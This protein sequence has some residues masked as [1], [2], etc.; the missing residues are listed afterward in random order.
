MTRRVTRRTVLKAGLIGNPAVAVAGGGATYWWWA[1][2]A[3]D[4]VG[5]VSFDHPL[6]IPPLADSEIDG[7]GRRV[8]ELVAQEGTSR[9][10]P[11]V[12]SETWGFNGSYLGLLAAQ[13]E[14]RRLS[15]SPGERAEIIVRM[16]PGG[17]VVLRSYQP[18]L[19]IDWFTNGVDGGR[20][21]FDLLELRAANTLAPSSPMPNRL[22]SPPDLAD[23][24]W[25]AAADRIFAL[26]GNKIN[27]NAMDMTRV[28]AVVE[29][30]TTEVWQVE[31]TD[32]NFHNVHVH[33]VQFHITT[34]NG[35]PPAPEF[36]GRKDTVF[37]Q[38]G[39]VAQ[40]A[41]R[42]TDYTDPNLPCMFHCHRLRHEDRGMMGQFVVVEPGQLPTL[43]N[44]AEHDEEGDQN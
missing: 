17:N 12:V 40:L 1:S 38:P 29:V 10:L 35:E 16:R 41:M 2:A 9:L 36:A 11:G 13:V 15:L 19:G 18:H 28:D 14:R 39:D 7:N 27:G 8:F 33:D 4:T 32:G 21:Q 20:D 3:V 5:Q 23:T 22:G 44:H 34:V 43:L 30:D 24:V 26:Q 37:L 42:F 25:N 6:N 31:N